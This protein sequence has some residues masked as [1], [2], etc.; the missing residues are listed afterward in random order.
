MDENLGSILLIQ[1]QPALE[2]PLGMYFLCLV[3]C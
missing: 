3:T 2:F 1:T